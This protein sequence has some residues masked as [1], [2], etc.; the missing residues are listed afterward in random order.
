MA[1]IFDFK[2]SES[3]ARATLA[4]SVNAACEV[5]LFPGVRYERWDVTPPPQANAEVQPRKRR[6]KKRAVEMAD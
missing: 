5:I 1:I 3:S 6:A 2:P 4:R